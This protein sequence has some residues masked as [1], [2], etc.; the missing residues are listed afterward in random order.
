MYASPL[1]LL[2]KAARYAGERVAACIAWALRR[3]WGGR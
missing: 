2:R 3:M 1:S